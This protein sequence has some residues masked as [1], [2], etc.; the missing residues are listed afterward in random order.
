MLSS[1]SYV[2]VKRLRKIM[3]R[4]LKLSLKITFLNI[5]KIIHYCTMAVVA[6]LASEN[7]FT[8]FPLA[9][10]GVL[11]PGLRT[12]DHMLSPP[13]TPAEV[14]EGRGAQTGRGRTTIDVSKNL[15]TFFL[16]PFLKFS[17]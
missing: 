10:M 7:Q 5:G 8:K 14:R 12:L 6:T 15:E 13:L 11:L 2:V 4:I 16:S 9:P 3:L 1:E 17:I